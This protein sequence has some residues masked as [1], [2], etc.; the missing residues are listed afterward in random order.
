MPEDC[1][2]VGTLRGASRFH[3]RFRILE[4]DIHKPEWDWT[5]LVL[6][7]PPRHLYSTGC[8]VYR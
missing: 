8:F 4:Q 7:D 6:T 3:M 2:E 1:K 5:I